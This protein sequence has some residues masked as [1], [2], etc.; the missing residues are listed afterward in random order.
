VGVGKT[1]GGGVWGMLGTKL[2]WAIVLPPSTWRKPVGRVE[3]SV[4]KQ[5]E[6][7]PMI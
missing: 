4:Y 6:V 3:R 2:V 5:G 1:S 7:L